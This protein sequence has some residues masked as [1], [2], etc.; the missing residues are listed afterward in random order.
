MIA[1]GRSPNAARLGVMPKPAATSSS[2]RRSCASR[3]PA[4]ERQWRIAGLPVPSARARLRRRFVSCASIGENAR[5]CPARSRRWPP[6]AGPRRRRRSA[7]SRSSSTLGRLVGMDSHRDVQPREPLGERQRV[8][9]RAR[10]P[11]GHQD[12]LHTGQARAT[13]DEIDVRREAVGL[14]MGVAVDQAHRAS[15]APCA[16]RPQPASAT[17]RGKADSGRASPA[18][19]AWA[20]Q[21]SSSRS[22]GPPLP[23][24]PYG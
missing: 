4:A 12:P 24:A 5:S 3:C 14:E 18:R 21:A 19:P 6:R 17:S 8:L 7:P 15:I 16:D 22:G 2:T 1:G 23:S 13:D 20:P 10:V 9:R 11:A